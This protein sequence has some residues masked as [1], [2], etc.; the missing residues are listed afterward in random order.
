MVKINSLEN[1]LQVVYKC[2]LKMCVFKLDLKGSS[3]SIKRRVERGNVHL[4]GQSAPHLYRKIYVLAALSTVLWKHYAAK[5][6]LVAIISG[7]T[8][9]EVSYSNNY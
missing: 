4:S 1:T 3:M 7:N 8:E 9:I 6:I 5:T 2:G